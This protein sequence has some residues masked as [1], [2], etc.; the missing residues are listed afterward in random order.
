VV[1]LAKAHV[2]AINR[3]VSSTNKTPYEVFNLGTGKGLSVLEVIHSFEKATGQKVNFV[4][5]PRRAGDIS[6]V[7]ADTSLANEELGWKAEVSMEDTLL[8]AWNWE[9]H[10]RNSNS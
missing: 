8:S 5:K 10:I 1:D 7:Y 6:T 3:L 2:V 9:K 4:F